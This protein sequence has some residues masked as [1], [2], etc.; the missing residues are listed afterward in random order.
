MD[1]FN[2][3]DDQVKGKL[4]KYL[5]GGKKIKVRV[6]VID[7]EQKILKLTA[8]PLLLT[9]DLEILKSYNDPKADT[10]YY[11]TLVSQNAYGFT[12]I[13]DAYVIENQFIVKKDIDSN[14]KKNLIYNQIFQL[15]NK[16]KQKQIYYFSIIK[17]LF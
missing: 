2:V 16:L 3:R 8:K 15:I 7:A 11:G 14:H 13:G 12:K 1:E 17:Y 10:P 4:P 9:E 6:L 5:E